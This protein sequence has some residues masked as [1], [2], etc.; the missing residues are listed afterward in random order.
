MSDIQNKQMKAETTVRVFGY[1]QAHE[2]T[3]AELAM[4]SGGLQGTSY[5]D[6]GSS[7]AADDCTR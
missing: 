3:P 2:L 1:T 5:C 4:V 7:C 6:T